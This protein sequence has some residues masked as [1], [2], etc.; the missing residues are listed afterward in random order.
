MKTYWLLQLYTQL[1]QLWNSSLKKIQAWMDGI[2]IHDL[3][4]TSAMLYQL[5]YQAIWEL[6]TMWVPNIP[7]EDEGCKWILYERS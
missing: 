4:N 7:I 1:K 5:S 3:R 6:V 2:Q